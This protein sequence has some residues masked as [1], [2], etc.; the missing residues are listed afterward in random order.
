MLCIESSGY[1]TAL[2]KARIPYLETRAEGAGKIDHVRVFLLKFRV[3]MVPGR[4]RLH[5]GCIDIVYLTWVGCCFEVHESR[6]VQL[7]GARSARRKRD[8]RP[9]ISRNRYPR[10]PWF[11]ETSSRVTGHDL[12]GRFASSYYYFQIFPF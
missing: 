3:F 12:I 4:V 8:L 1:K 11:R 6:G 5:Y 7:I 10:T 2:Y 9:K